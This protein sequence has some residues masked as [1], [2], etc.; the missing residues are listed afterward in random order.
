[1]T[2]NNL[3]QY[4]CVFT[5]GGVMGA[6]GLTISSWQFWVCLILMLA[7]GFLRHHEG[8]SK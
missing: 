6:T 5:F 1:M 2:Y 3:A 7:Y 8:A 4:G